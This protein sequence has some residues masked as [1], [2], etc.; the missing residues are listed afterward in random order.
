VKYGAPV[1]D[2]VNIN[3]AGYGKTFP[4][5]LPAHSGRD[6]HHTGP[7]QK[8]CSGQPNGICPVK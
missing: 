8:G 7:G 3:E 5:V 1:G 6:S 2:G 4:Y